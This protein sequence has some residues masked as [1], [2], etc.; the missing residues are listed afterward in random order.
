MSRIRFRFLRP[1]SRPQLGQRSNSGLSYISKTAEANLMK[2][3]NRMKHNKE[4]DHA[5]GHNQVRCQIVPKMV[6]QQ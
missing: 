1:R 6:S 4:V 2:L 5:Q 3:H